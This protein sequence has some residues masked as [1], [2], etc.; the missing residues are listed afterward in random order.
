M[1]TTER[2][3]GHDDNCD[4]V[5]DELACNSTIN[6]TTGCSGFVVA[7]LPDHGYMLCTSGRKDWSH[8]R[9]ACVAQGMRLAW[10]DSADE[11]TEVSKKVDALSG[12]AEVL[13]GATDAADEGEWLWF[14]G[15]QFWQGNQYG[16]SVDGLFNNWAEGTPNNDNGGE[17]CVVL[18]P[19]TTFWGDRI[20]SATYAYLCEEPD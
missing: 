18:N 12:E 11:N 17:D 10:L 1:P 8:A 9:D 13:F 16:E 7:S 19:M 3:N 6:G 4:E 15:D 2:C 14:G 5:I 20:C